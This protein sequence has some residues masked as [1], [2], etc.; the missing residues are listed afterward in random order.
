MHIIQELDGILNSLNFIDRKLQ[1]REHKLAKK[2]SS[3][4]QIH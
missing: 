4:W 3:M 2:Q 1:E